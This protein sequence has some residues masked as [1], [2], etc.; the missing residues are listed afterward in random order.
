MNWKDAF[1]R[2]SQAAPDFG[3]AGGALP[4]ASA[5]VD[6]ATARAVQARLNALGAQP[7]LTVDGSWGPKSAAATASF[8][9][10]RGLKADGIPGPDTLKALGVPIPPAPKVPNIPA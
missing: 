2:A 3:A 5:L 1:T 7:L 6:G 8:Q 10:S 4:G 9:S